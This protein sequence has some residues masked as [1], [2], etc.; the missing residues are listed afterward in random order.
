MPALKRLGLSNNQLGDNETTSLAV[1][2]RAM[3]ALETLNL[4]R[5]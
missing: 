2:L 3:P 1:A 5:N 4:A